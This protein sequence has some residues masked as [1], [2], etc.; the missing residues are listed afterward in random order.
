VNRE[1]LGTTDYASEI[2]FRVLFYRMTL[3]A[4]LSR[5]SCGNAMAN[6][7]LRI[8]QSRIVGSDFN[9]SHYRY[10]IPVASRF[11]K[12]V[13]QRLLEH[14]SDP[15]CG[16]G[17]KHSEW[18]WRHFAPRF[19]ISHELVADLRAIAM[20]DD[21]APSIEHEVNDW[22]E[23]GPRVSELVR[24]GRTLTWR[25]Q[26]IATNRYHRSARRFRHL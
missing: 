17:N 14:V 25:G 10:D 4:E 13:L 7:L 15:P 8:T 21:D 12:S 22:P 26:R 20:H 9:L 23:T 3:S 1:R 18:E 5:T 6:E 11:T 24:N 2:S 16:F 19:F